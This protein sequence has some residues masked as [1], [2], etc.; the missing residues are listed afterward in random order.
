[1]NTPQYS[2]DYGMAPIEDVIAA[3]EVKTPL[4][5]EEAK[6]NYTLAID[7]ITEN[8]SLTQLIQIK[9]DDLS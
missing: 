9:L 6:K 8:S 4:D 7:N 1:M 3:I 5:I 2:R